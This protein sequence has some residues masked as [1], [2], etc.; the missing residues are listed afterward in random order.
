MVKPECLCAGPKAFRRKSQKPDDH[1]LKASSQRASDASA[2]I[3]PLHDDRYIALKPALKLLQIGAR[4]CLHLHPAQVVVPAGS[5]RT[6]WNAQLRRQDSAGFGEG[7]GGQ[8]DA[9]LGL[10]DIRPFQGVQAHRRSPFVASL[11]GIHDPIPP[12]LRGHPDPNR[13]SPLDLFLDSPGL[14]N[15]PKHYLDR[16]AAGVRR[17]GQW[18]RPGLSPEVTAGRNQEQDRYQQR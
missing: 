5:G 7:G 10:Y 2:L 16:S 6:Q 4:E 3:S 14:E 9:L 8:G 17:Q 18:R 13:E 1:A 12:Q 15:G 11:L